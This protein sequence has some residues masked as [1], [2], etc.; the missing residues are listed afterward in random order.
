MLLAANAPGHC[1]LCQLWTGWLGPATCHSN[2]ED[3]Q[4]DSQLTD[5]VQRLLRDYPPRLCCQT[6]ECIFAT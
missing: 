1:S 4:G 5:G 3:E 2:S 6:C